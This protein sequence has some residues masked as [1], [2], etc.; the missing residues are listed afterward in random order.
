MKVIYTV[1]QGPVELKRTDSMRQVSALLAQW[2]RTEGH[3]FEVVQQDDYGRDGERRKP[4]LI[5][6]FILREKGD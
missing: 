2:L 4:V 1:T 5:Q 3:W 6:Q